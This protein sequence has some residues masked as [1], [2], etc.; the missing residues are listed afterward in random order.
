ME[1]GTSEGLQSKATN[2][3][4]I[5]KELEFGSDNGAEPGSAFD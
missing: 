5:K 3:G 2:N 1:K 4:A